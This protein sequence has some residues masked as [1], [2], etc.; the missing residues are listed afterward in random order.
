MV[1]QNIMAERYGGAERERDQAQDISFKGTHPRTSPTMPH[2][3][4]AHPAMN[5][6]TD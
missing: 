1:K 4:I 2:L 3:L 5:S 6:S